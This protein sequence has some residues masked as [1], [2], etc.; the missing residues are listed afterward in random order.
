MTRQERT[1]L[2]AAARAACMLAMR[3]A[4]GPAAMSSSRSV[5]GRP[6]VTSVA[7]EITRGL[8]E[9]ASPVASVW[10]AVASV[11][12]AASLALGTTHAALEDSF[13][14]G[15]LDAYT[16]IYDHDATLV[17][18]PDGRCVRGRAEIRAAA[19]PL[20]ALRPR[21]SSVVVR[22]LQNDDL[23]L[24]QARWELAALADDGTRT[25]LSGH[26]II[27][28]RRQPDGTWR[29]VLDDPMSA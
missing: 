5:A 11:R 7:P 10:M 15:D 26:G 12:V 4:M 1:P 25:Q 29:V 23:A 6:G 21:K 18:P 17:M 27:V 22:K 13:S 14:R 2:A 20:I 3:A 19:A 24:T 8:P 16:E 28:S 9:P